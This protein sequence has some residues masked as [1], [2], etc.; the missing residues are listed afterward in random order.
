MEGDFG[1]WC[2]ETYCRGKNFI[3]T[4]KLKYEQKYPCHCG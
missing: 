1:E 4:L 2:F 3:C